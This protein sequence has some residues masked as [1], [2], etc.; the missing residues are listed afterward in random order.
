MNTM[1][2]KKILNGLIIASVVY[3]GCF[4]MMGQGVKRTV[5]YEAEAGYAKKAKPPARLDIRFEP[6]L[7]EKIISTNLFFD[8]VAVDIGES[9]TPII[10]ELVI[11]NVPSGKHQLLLRNWSYRYK[12]TRKSVNAPSGENIDVIMEVKGNPARHLPNLVE[13]FFTL[14]CLA[15]FVAFAQH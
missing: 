13:G 2:T 11:K 7:A 10:K 4:P 6:P 12:T 3:T 9:N 14:G 8:G 15:S 5:R 1:R